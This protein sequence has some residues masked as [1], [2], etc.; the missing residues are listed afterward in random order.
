MDEEAVYYLS[1]IP[2]ERLYKCAQECWEEANA[3]FQETYHLYVDSGFSKE[4]SALQ[5]VGEKSSDIL[6]FWNNELF[7]ARQ[8]FLRGR[9]VVEPDI[10]KIR[11]MIIKNIKKPPTKN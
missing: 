11:E 5:E 2:M 3:S 7:K 4:F 6:T 9:K 8:K 10:G 1:Y